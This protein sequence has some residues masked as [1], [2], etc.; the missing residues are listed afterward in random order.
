MLLGI[1]E[2]MSTGTVFIFLCVLYLSWRIIDRR[3]L[4]PGPLGYPIIGSFPRF[5]FRQISTIRNLWKQY[6]DLY[7]LHFGSKT[8]VFVNGYETLR[9]VF[10]KNADKTSDR[11]NLYTLEVLNEK[12]GN[13]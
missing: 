8:V 6:G 4:P 13:A 12:S 9:E 11:P 10:V 5:D 2:S 7:T 1:L 3:N